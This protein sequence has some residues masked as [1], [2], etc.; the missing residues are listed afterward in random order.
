MEF[1]EQGP[2]RRVKLVVEIPEVAKEALRL[3]SA[4]VGLT[5]AETIAESLKGVPEYETALRNLQTKRNA[6]IILKGVEVA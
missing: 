6:R 1:D 3:F 4:G 2:Y 5:M